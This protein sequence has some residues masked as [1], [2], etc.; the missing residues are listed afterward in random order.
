[1]KQYKPLADAKV[2]A[3][4][5]NLG[6]RLAAL[7]ERPKAA[8]EFMVLEDS[9]VNAFAAPGGFIFITTGLLKRLKDE[10]ELAAVLGHE[11]GHVVK[12]HALKRMQRAAVAELGL[13]VVASLLKGSAQELTRQLG[14]I[15]SN[16]LLL[17]NGREAE[18]ESDEQGLHLAARAGY[19]PEGMLGV[20]NMLMAQS[21]AG[22]GPFAEMLSTHPPSEQRIQ[23]AQILLPK[24]R[25]PV[26]RGAEAYKAAVLDRL[27]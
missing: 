9:Q 15:A 16:L 20:Q 1:L 25:G 2:Q 24:Y 8:W 3:Y 17:R 4:V 10:A 13:E 26:A 22:K 11:V 14:S 19:A 5:S 23:Q 21:G 7:S 12:R 27:P 6:L 18:L